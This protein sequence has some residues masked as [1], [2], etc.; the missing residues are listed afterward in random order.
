MKR[1]PPGS[2][3]SL[4]NSL[5]PTTF[6]WNYWYQENMMVLLILYIPLRSDETWRSRLLHATWFPFISH[7]VQMKRT[8]RT[9]KESRLTTLYPT[10]FR[11]NGDFAEPGHAGN[12]FISHYVQ[13]KLAVRT[14]LS[15]SRRFLYIPLRS[16]ETEQHDVKKSDDG[17][18]YIPLRSDETALGKRGS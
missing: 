12:H 13:M 11:W 16:D 17:F 10:T 8:A 4:E 15:S 2:G 7:Y 9:S 1:W 3:V 5:Y 14:P 6:R 18:L